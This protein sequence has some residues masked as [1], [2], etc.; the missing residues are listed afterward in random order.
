MPDPNKV[1]ENLRKWLDDLAALRIHQDPNDPDN[2]DRMP[3]TRAWNA[4]LK[5]AEQAA[6]DY[7][8]LFG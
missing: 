7:A 5:Q 4:A 1:R 8:D 3:F 6:N 2:P